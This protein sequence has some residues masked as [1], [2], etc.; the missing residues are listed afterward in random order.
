MPE[1]LPEFGAP[2]VIETVLSAQF[3]R[4]PNFSSALSGWFWKQYLSSDWAKAKDA[5]RIEDQFERFDEPR[6]V[7]SPILIRQSSEMESE[8]VQLIR[9]DDERLIQIQ[10]TRF[11]LNWKREHGP[12]PTYKVLL[13]EFRELF[14][15]FSMFVQDA[16][17]GRLS[18]N[19]W[20]VTYVNHIPRGSL[21]ASPYDWKR[22][23]PGLYTPAVWNGSHC[24]T[25]AGSWRFI[26]EGKRGR[27]YINLQH[28][29]TGVSGPD[30]LVIQ[31]TAR[32]PV[33]DD[34]GWS[35]GSGFSLGHEYIVRTFDA[36]TSEEAQ[37][38][39]L[40]KV[41]TSV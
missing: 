39:W 37:A 20:E 18:L 24:E 13:P 11:I 15:K 14:A 30:A 3:V 4:L 2:P 31:F 5:P 23:L 17:L 35:V 9:S 32:G 33:D 34:K 40:K 6:T 41:R 12:Y 22:I 28:G 38:S 16:G 21:W 19:Q 26:L 8:R 36:I 25:L 7:V 1:P 29:R 27:L 10:N